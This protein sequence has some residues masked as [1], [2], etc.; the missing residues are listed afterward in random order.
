MKKQSKKHG[1]SFENKPKNNPGAVPEP[2]DSRDEPKAPQKVAQ[3]AHRQPKRVKGT[4]KDDTSTPKETTEPPKGRQKTSKGFQKGIQNTEE[5]QP[6]GCL[7]VSSY[8][9][10]E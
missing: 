4:Q 10:P 1:T 3:T 5:T 8:I 9:A 7:R 2:T 6:K